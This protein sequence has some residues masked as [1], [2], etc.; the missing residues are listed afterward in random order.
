M[1]PPYGGELV[2]LLVDD[3]RAAAMKTAAR[4]LASLTLDERGLCDLEQLAVGGFSPLRGFMNQ[5][6]YQRVLAEGRLADGTPWPLPITLPVTPGDGIAEGKTLALRDVYGNLLAFLHIEELYPYDRDAEANALYGT[7]DPAHPAV[8]D[9]LRSPGHCAAGRLEVLRIPPHFDF[10]DLRRTPSALRSHITTLAGPN[11]GV[12][13]YPTSTLLHRAEEAMLQHALAPQG[14]IVLVQPIVGVTRPGDIDHYARL[15]CLRA[16]VDC[17]DVHASIVLNLLPL[18][19]RPAGLRHTEL[20]AILAQNHGATDL[21]NIPSPSGSQA[22]HGGDLGREGETF[23]GPDRTRVRLIPATPM[24]FLPVENRHAP[25]DAVPPGTQTLSLTETEI[26][27]DYLAQGRPLPEWFTHPTVARIL[28]ETHPP[29]SRQG[30]TIWFTGISGS[31][32]S[33]V[34]HALIERLAEFGRNASLLDGDEI[35]TH[36]SKGLTFS[37]DD[38][39]IN[40][41][42]VGYVAGLVAQ[43][44]GTTLC[45]VISPY[46]AIRNEARAMSRGNF[47]EVFCDTPI[48]VC[49]QRDVKGHYARARAAL[50]E[51]KPIGFTG[52]D[53]PYEPP[54]TPE[55]TLNTGTQS[56]PECVDVIVATL[57]T[58]GYLR[59]RDT[60]DS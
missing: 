36:L 52:V 41:R 18:S 4:D 24:V 34:A 9:L 54:L 1:N 16:F 48:T 3:A 8:A 25:A 7:T 2:D 23:S 47:V 46:R 57:R 37:K 30:L 22:A 14:G 38:R 53:D 28:A 44:G 29:K 33:T 15:R 32:K 35:R 13:A 40:I 58:L 19:P 6:D 17:A 39:D 50:A 12:I 11:T 45:S 55:V 60:L 5:A 59:P 27:D 26:R 31:G 10:V 20:L 49:E 51:G 42:R 43:H 56:V 21:L